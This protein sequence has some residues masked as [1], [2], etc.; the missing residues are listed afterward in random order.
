MAGVFF[1][2]NAAVTASSDPET[3]VQLLA[4]A[5]HRVVI[6]EISVGAKGSTPAS[7]PGKLTLQLQATAGSGGN[8]ITLAKTKSIDTETLQTTGQFGVFS[9]E[10]TASTVLMVW[11]L[12]E[13]GSI[14]WLPMPDARPIVVGGQRVGLVFS[15]ASGWSAIE[16]SIL[17]E[18]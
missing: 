10:P 5:N 7:A 14:S 16:V 6:H 12:H 18:E 15:L 9:A 17:C 13:Q 4:A 3:L 11:T 2:A 8:A 1:R